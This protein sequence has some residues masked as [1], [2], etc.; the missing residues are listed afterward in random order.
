MDP[1]EGEGRRDAIVE[2]R[3]SVD[4]NEHTVHSVVTP[5]PLIRRSPETLTSEHDGRNEPL[6][7]SAGTQLLATNLERRL[8]QIAT[9]VPP[10]RH[11]L[12]VTGNAPIPR[13]GLNLEQTITADEAVP[14]VP[15]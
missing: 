9:P 11:V 1:Q 5:T 6:P 13:T 12:A 15:V 10:V 3:N 7:S 8:D 2:A 4:T 14:P